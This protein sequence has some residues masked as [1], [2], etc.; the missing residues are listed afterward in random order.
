MQNATWPEIDEYLK[1][2]SRPTTLIPLSPVE[3]HG[4]HLPISTDFL[5]TEAVTKIAAEQYDDCV[6]FPTI[7][8]MCCGISEPTTG[9]YPITG[10]TIRS[11]ALDLV[12]A[13]HKKGFTRILFLSCHGG[14]SKERILEAIDI[15]K[16]T[17]IDIIAD[18]LCFPDVFRPE[19]GLVETRY[20]LHAGEIET[21]VMMI[22]HPELVRYQPPA[23]FHEFVEGRP[24][25]LSRSGICGNP[26]KATAEKGRRIIE[27]A[28][29]GIIDWLKN[30]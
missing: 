25:K 12:I 21:S 27:I 18:I 2:S 1:T 30:R 24:T 7:P 20:D 6:I 23:D 13:C 5:I 16:S 15:S 26:R 19:P 8:L 22:I 4:P 14:F 9:T 17:G 28:V 11:I 10:E 29:E 3:E